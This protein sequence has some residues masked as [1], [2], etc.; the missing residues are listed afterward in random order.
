MRNQV[1]KGC[2][3]GGGAVVIRMVFV[4]LIEEITRLFSV[5]NYAF[6][7]I[8]SFFKLSSQCRSVIYADPDPTRLF[9]VGPD[10]DPTFQFDADPCGS[11]I[12]I[13]DCNTC[14]TVFFSAHRTQLQ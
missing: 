6:R 3:W 9:D 14:L 12:H 11:W 5:M 7:P 13:T 1:I 4:C 2:R 8:G 10:P